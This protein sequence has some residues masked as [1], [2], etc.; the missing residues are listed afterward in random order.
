MG[1]RI[2]GEGPRGEPTAHRPSQPEQTQPLQGRA[3]GRGSLQG[4]TTVDR[5]EQLPSLPNLPPTV[6]ERAKPLPESTLSRT[7]E[8]T[9]ALYER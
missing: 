7:V 3:E 2:E 9:R 5:S 8:R 1:G 4:P 6:H